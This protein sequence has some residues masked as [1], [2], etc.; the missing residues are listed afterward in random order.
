[1][2]LS[3][4][5]AKQLLDGKQIPL[6]IEKPGAEINAYYKLNGDTLEAAV[7]SINANKDVSKLGENGIDQL[8]SDP[9]KN[10]NVYTN[11][12]LVGEG[13]SALKQFQATAIDAAQ[14]IG[15]KKVRIYGLDI[16]NADLKK[17]L[18]KRYGFEPL[19][20]LYNLEKKEYT[21]SVDG[22]VKE[23]DLSA[24][25]P[26]TDIRVLDG[27]DLSVSPAPKDVAPVG[28]IPVDRRTL[29]NPTGEV[30]YLD[31]VKEII[32]D[33]SL[34]AKT[35]SAKLNEIK[36][37]LNDVDSLA[38]DEPSSK[39][40][41]EA[42]ALIDEQIARDAQG[43]KKTVAL[44]DFVKKYPIPFELSERSKILVFYHASPR[45]TFKIGENGLIN[46]LRAREGFFMA[47]TPEQAGMEVQQTNSPEV[48]KIEIDP[49]VKSSKIIEL[50]NLESSIGGTENMNVKISPQDITTFNE[51]F[52]NGYV[53]ITKMY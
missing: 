27:V 39:E 48:F 9:N 5:K 42:N 49:R 41:N 32:D 19:K 40:I 21:D 31:R 14:S 6:H 51:L 2:G 33:N 35:R 28:D 10:I 20:D 44:D 43:I 47:R 30:S 12:D 8:L 38:R 17:V 37:E 18:L 11:P 3:E 24:E 36:S 1:M 46:P 13:I 26:L 23:I 16:M 4:D 15:S 53:R 50:V 7:L 25:K 52:N 22:I 29:F 45:G 34:N